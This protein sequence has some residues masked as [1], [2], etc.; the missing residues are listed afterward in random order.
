MPKVSEKQQIINQIDEI[1]F[2]LIIDDDQRNQQEIDELL[3]LKA[4]ISSFRYFNSSV[5]IPKSIEHRILLLT[6]PSEE[7]REAFRMN[8]ETFLYILTKIQSH[9]IFKNNSRHQQQPIWLQLLVALERFGFD[10]TSS[11]VGKISRNLGI[12]KGTVILYT[13]RVIEAI[14]SIQNEFIKWP[15]RRR[16]KITSEVHNEK[17]YDFTEKLCT[18]I[19]HIKEIYTMS[20]DASNSSFK[21]SDIEYSSFL[22]PEGRRYFVQHANQILKL[23]DLITRCMEQGY[24]HGIVVD[25]AGD[26]SMIDLIPDLSKSSQII[27]YVKGEIRLLTLEEFMDEKAYFYVVRFDKDSPEKRT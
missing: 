1:L 21:M 24:H 26:I 17:V 5:T 3:D 9:Q 13:S 18:S 16:R 2:L 12:S 20:Y 19:A 10:G 25:T 27:E 6:L 11:S 22:N 7:F 4:H 14:L 15:D 8:K 23:G